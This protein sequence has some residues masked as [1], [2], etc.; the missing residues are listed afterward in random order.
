[1]G[2]GVLKG[3]ESGNVD[4]EAGIPVGGIW[5]LKWEVW[6]GRR[7]QGQG[8]KTEGFGRGF[9]SPGRGFGDTTVMANK[10][11]KGMK[12]KRRGRGL[13]T[14]LFGGDWVYWDV[15]EYNGDPGEGAALGSSGMYRHALGCTGMSWRVMAMRGEG[16]GP[17]EEFGVLTLPIAMPPAS[18]GETMRCHWGV[19]SPNKG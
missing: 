2:L 9:G 15:W 19:S 10:K 12:G 5:G 6:G 11:G 14:V 18:C 8:T 4:E 3:W 17:A 1:M 16:L 13:G 7:K